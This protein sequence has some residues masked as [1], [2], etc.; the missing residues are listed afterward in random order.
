MTGF[1]IRQK[2]QIGDRVEGRVEEW[3]TGIGREEGRQERIRWMTGFE[4][5][6][7]DQIGD[8][9]EGRLEEA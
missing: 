6:Q 7:E 3:K 5:R 9:V 4:I 2:D 1:E 8:K